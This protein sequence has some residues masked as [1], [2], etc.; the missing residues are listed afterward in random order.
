[1]HNFSIIET[2][3]LQSETAKVFKIKFLYLLR[4]FKR[5][6]ELKEGDIMN[7]DQLS[8]SESS[9]F[10]LKLMNHRYWHIANRP[11]IGCFLTLTSKSFVFK[12]ILILN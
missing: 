1:M 6:P 2:V 11:R 9:K 10:I 4:E 8:N 3:K 12:S 7:I 5:I